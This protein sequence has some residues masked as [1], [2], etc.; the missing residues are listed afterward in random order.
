[1][2]EGRSS[3]RGRPQILAGKGWHDATQASPTDSL[4]NRLGGRW[5]YRRLLADSSDDAIPSSGRVPLRS[6]LRALVQMAPLLCNRVIGEY[7]QRYYEGHCMRG[8]HRVAT[9]ALLWS[10]LASTAAQAVGSWGERNSRR[11]RNRCDHPHLN[12]SRREERHELTLCRDRKSPS[13]V[14][15][16]GN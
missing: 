2:A 7:L 1:M 6:K 9:L 12:A 16:L 11:S 10:V 5:G 4:R 14:W 8:R 3:P 15:S 13:E